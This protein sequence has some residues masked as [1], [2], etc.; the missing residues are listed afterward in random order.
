MS[1][2]IFDGMTGKEI[3]EYCARKVKEGSALYQEYKNN[4]DKIH[5]YLANKALLMGVSSSLK[6]EFP[7]EEK[8][9][10]KSMSNIF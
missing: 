2:A 10:D 5:D 6:I 8:E 3:E 4:P 7:G 1:D 9:I